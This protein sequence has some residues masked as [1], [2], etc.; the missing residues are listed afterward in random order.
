MTKYSSR[1]RKT[2]GDTRKGEGET[3]RDGERGR[4]RKNSEKK[5]KTNKHHPT[6][7]RTG[8]PPTRLDLLLTTRLAGIALEITGWVPPVGRS[9]G[10]WMGRKM[11]WW[12]KK[13][14]ET[15]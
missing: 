2:G 9:E 15:I 7:R 14:Y 6:G 1:E 12:V 3:G 4:K 13:Q 8:G 11:F 10:D 5:K